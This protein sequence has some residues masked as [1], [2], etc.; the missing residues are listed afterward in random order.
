MVDAY[1][2]QATHELDRVES[3]VELLDQSITLV[4]Q[5]IDENI[6][7]SHALTALRIIPELDRYSRVADRLWDACAVINQL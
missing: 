1:R 7:Q 4:M 3:E 5:Q 2:R 6:V